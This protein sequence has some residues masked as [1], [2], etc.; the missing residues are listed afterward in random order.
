MSRKLE[1]AVT[2]AALQARYQKFLKEN[3]PGE[4]VHARH[5][6]VQTESAAR[7][8]IK[9]LQGGADFENLAGKIHRAVGQGRRRFGL[10]HL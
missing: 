10:F 9:Q 5:I 3:A 7:A 4:E 1:G 8:I 2:D 6:L